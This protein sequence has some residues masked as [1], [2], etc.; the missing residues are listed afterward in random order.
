M[1]IGRRPSRTCGDGTPILGV[2]NVEEAF[3][4]MSTSKSEISVQA[5]ADQVLSEIRAVLSSIDDESVRRF[6]GAVLEAKRIVLYGAGRMGIM[7]STFA[8]R[9]AQLGFRS[10][11]LNEP[12]TPGIGDGDLLILGSGSGE[13]QTVYDVA[14]LAKKRGAQLALITARPDSRIGRLADVIVPFSV[15]TKDGPGA[16]PSTIQ[17]MTTVADQ[18]LLILF[19]IIV[20]LLMQATNQTSEDLWRRHRNLE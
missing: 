4:I 12:T 11:A 7:S 10:H 13:T 1:L 8:M 18:S 19:D 14:V 20:L 9:L 16:G 15:P 3:E 6:V 5:Y 17:P 2:R